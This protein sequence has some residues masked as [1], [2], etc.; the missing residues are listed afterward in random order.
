MIG[1]PF[2]QQAL[3]QASGCNQCCG[4]I[5]KPI[6]SKHKPQTTAERH[7]NDKTKQERIRKKVQMESEI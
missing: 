2:G 6:I 1:F 7:V 4:C 3:A 5:R